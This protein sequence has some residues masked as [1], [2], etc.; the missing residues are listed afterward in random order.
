MRCAGYPAFAFMQLGG[1]RGFWRK[2]PK[3]TKGR[4]IAWPSGSMFIP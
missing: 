2:T 4:E 3:Q 1:V